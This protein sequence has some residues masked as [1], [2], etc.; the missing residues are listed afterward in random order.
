MATDYRYRHELKPSATTLTDIG[1]PPHLCHAERN[2]NV[3][4]TNNELSQHA[5]NRAQKLS[6]LCEIVKSF[7]KNACTTVRGG[8]HYGRPL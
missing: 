3:L 2:A 6:S 8:S 1:L 4:P 7:A 5:R